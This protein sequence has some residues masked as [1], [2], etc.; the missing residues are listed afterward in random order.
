MILLIAELDKETVSEE[1]F[2][3]LGCAEMIK[4]IAGE[5]ITAVFPG[6]DREEKARIF[7]EETGIDVIVLDNPS[8]EEY[9]LEGYCGAI[10]ALAIKLNPGF[11]IVP[12]TSRGSDY[13]PYLA[14]ALGM[15]CITG[16][17]EILKR[18]GKAVFRR[19]AWHGKV[20]EDV[21]PEKAAVVTVFPGYFRFQPEPGHEIGKIE[22]MKDSTFPERTLLTETITGESSGTKLRDAD[23]IVA[24]GNGVPEE[25]GME[26]INELA[27]CFSRSAVGGS[28]IACDRGLVDYS[29][30]VGMT[31]QKVTPGVYIAC[32]ISGSLQHIMGMMGSGFIIAINRDP[33]API[34]QYADIAVIDDLTFFIPCLIDALSER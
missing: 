32:G 7:R 4:G 1:T 6:Y 27:S 25:E 19:T 2:E 29:N 18:E 15:E 22:V 26:L 12:H 16:T 30:Q 11:I 24:A 14:A 8:L 28:R 3:A 17:E 34:F 10:S 5:D 23:V 9:S 31:G 13:G 20:K 21:I 33:N